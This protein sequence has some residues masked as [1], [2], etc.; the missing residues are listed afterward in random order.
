MKNIY[1]RI[2]SLFAPAPLWHGLAISQI[3]G[4]NM[5][6]QNELKKQYQDFVS[7]TFDND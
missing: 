6:I 5:A 7:P 1:T 3:M 2:A 4:E